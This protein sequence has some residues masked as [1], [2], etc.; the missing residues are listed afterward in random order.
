MRQFV[1]HAGARHGELFFNLAQA[2]VDLL[3]LLGKF[4]PVLLLLARIL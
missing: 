3:V 2:F 1:F 4:L